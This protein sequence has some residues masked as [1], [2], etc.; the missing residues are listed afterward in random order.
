MTARY[1]QN[2]NKSAHNFCCHFR[3]NFFLYSYVSACS[4]HC[5][6]DSTKSIDVQWFDFLLTVKPA[7]FNF[8][9]LCQRDQ[10]AFVT[11][12]DEFSYF[13]QANIYF[14]SYF[15]SQWT[16]KSTCVL[17]IYRFLW[18]SRRAD[19]D[20]LE[21]NRYDWEVGRL[22][23]VL[24][25]NSCFD[26][27]LRWS[28]LY[29]ISGQLRYTDFSLHR[30]QILYIGTSMFV[31]ESHSSLIYFKSNVEIDSPIRDGVKS[32]DDV[33][34]SPILTLKFSLNRL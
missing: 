22:S 19:H 10:R 27:D 17:K 16:R 31:D 20:G 4:R 21:K 28:R 24:V 32:I 26:S 6:C 30:Q 3:W 7:N 15:R 33:L 14:T 2:K 29:L 11:K 18:I 13:L 9:C 12:K 25:F 34:R 8:N 23:T 5:S 1:A